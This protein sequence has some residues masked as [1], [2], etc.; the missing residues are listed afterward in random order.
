VFSV[1]MYKRMEEIEKVA[2]L[3]KGRAKG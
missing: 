3:L 1:H 2:K